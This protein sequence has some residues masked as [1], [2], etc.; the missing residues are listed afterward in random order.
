MQFVPDT[1]VLLTALM[2]PSSTSAQL[3]S[4]WRDRKIA[5]V[6]C[7]EQIE[8]IARVTRYP[9]IRARLLPALAGR[10]VNRLR[11]VPIVVEELPRVDVSPD[12]D[13]NYLLALS[14]VGQARFSCYRRQA[15]SPPE[16]TQVNPDRYSQGSDRILEGSRRLVTG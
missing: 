7:A 14:D 3:L 12:P 9:K 6:T 5:V 4:L 1:N 15:A 2:S 10:L 16:A 11:D 13:D 8:E